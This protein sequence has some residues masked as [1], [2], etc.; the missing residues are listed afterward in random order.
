V[1]VVEAPVVPLVTIALVVRCGSFVEAPEFNG[2]SHFREHLFFSANAS[3]PDKE[4]FLD[5][6]RELGM[7]LGPSLGG[8]TGEERTYYWFTLS[9]DS[10]DPVLAFI[11]AAVTTPLFLVED[12][13]RERQV[14]INEFDR[15]Q[16]YPHLSLNRAVNKAL[17]PAYY[18]RKNAPG[19][20]EV[21]LSVDRKKIETIDARY[22]LPNNAALFIG[23]DVEHMRA[24]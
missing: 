2:L 19:D 18:S 8:R 5:R 20:R 15:G 3:Y 16:S 23:G 17:W 4:K 11:S 13:E 21:I 6:T 9:K 7:T 1:F 10:L 14:I 12:V 24:F 22:Y